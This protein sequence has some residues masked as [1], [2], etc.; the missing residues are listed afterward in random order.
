MNARK[1]TYTNAGHCAPVLLRA[2]GEVVRL[3]A[4]G[5]V[6]GVFPEWTYGEAEVSLAPGD[7][8]LLFTDGVTKHPTRAMRNSAKIASYNSL[9]RCET[10]TPT[11]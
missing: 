10:A 6:L 7:R 9:P 5:A 2:D 4:G 8:L 11:S 1:V 3:E